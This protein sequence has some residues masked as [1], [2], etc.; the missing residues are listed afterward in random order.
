[1]NK[2]VIF[3]TGKMAEM[4]HFYFTHDSQY[5]T[6]AFTIDG[7]FIKDNSFQGLPAVAFEEVEKHYPPSEY[8]MFVAI[9]YKKI[10][11]LREEKYTEAKNRGYQLVSYVNSRSIIWGKFEYGDNCFVLENQV[12]Q[13]FV[14]IGNNV[15]L[16]SG[17]H[18]GH[19]VVIEDNCWISSHVVVSGGVR[20]GRNSFVGVNVTI[21]DDVVIG[22]ECIIGAGAII[23]RDAK[24]KG[25]YIAKSTEL[26]RLDS[27]N[28]EKMIGLSKK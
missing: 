20:I 14:K 21:R 6:V 15:V 26:Y 19:N 1:M 13:P 22:K 24:D 10:N 16:W 11:K 18:F 4:S 8:S 5:K 3:G 12:I 23:L 7:A 9:G 27:E 25:V 28:F 17:N 2:V